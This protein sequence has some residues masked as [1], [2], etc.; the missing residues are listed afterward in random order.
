MS[1]FKIEDATL[2]IV[3]AWNVAIIEPQW[4]VKNA[5]QVPSGTK[6]PIEMEVSMGLATNFRS[7]INDLYFIPSNDKFIIN[8]S[9]E[10]EELFKLA[11]FAAINLYRTLS[12][13]PIQAIGYNFTYVLDADENYTID[14]AN[15]AGTNNSEFYKR[16]N[17]IARPETNIQ[18]SLLLG[19][20]DAAVLNV[21]YNITSSNKFLKMNYHYQVNKDA[22]KIEKALGKFNNNYQHATLVNSALTKKG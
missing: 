20:D 3:G 19:A 12:H 8:P 10:N 13:T 22:K 14:I 4:I 7:K 5:L 16:I 18:H 2:V 1:T 21:Q 15:C 6:S 11:D 17:A 9:K